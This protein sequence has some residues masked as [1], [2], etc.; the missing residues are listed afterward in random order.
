MPSEDNLFQVTY[1]ELRRVALTTSLRHSEVALVPADLVKE[2]WH[3]LEKTPELAST[4]EPQFKR[5][6]AR[7]M[8]SL[9]RTAGKCVVFHDGLQTIECSDEEVLAMD[10]ALDRLSQTNPQQAALIECRFFAGMD[11]EE[12]AGLLGV[13]ENSIHAGWRAARAWLSRHLRC[14]SADDHAAEDST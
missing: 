9:I 2:A 4:S 8:R 5:V 10:V 6:A 3:N 14:E 13:P 1:D 12:M 7:A 11:A